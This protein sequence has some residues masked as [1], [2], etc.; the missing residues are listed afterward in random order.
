MYII[1]KF[2]WF[3][4]LAN[5]FYKIIWSDGVLSI[6]VLD[7]YFVANAFSILA[8]FFFCLFG[9]LKTSI[10]IGTVTVIQFSLVWALLFFTTR[11]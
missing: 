7:A 4:A 11:V 6:Y 1:P 2:S 10:I 9:E 3:N 8:A 5:F